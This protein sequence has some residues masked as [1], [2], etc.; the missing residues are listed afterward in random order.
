MATFLIQVIL[1]LNFY[2]SMVCLCLLS[3]SDPSQ[4]KR[5]IRSPDEAE[6]GKSQPVAQQRRETPPVS[7][8]I[9]L[10]EN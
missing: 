1:I 4:A 2:K 9:S 5:I 3:E 6:K 8:M 7:Y 10:Y